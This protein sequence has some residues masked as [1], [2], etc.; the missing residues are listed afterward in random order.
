MLLRGEYI[1]FKQ[2]LGGAWPQ[3]C[4]TDGSSPAVQRALPPTHRRLH[5]VDVPISY[6]QLQAIPGA[7]LVVRFNV[8]SKCVFGEVDMRMPASSL[9]NSL[10]KLSSSDERHNKGLGILAHLQPPT[11]AAI[12][13]SFATFGRGK[14]VVSCVEDGYIGP[15][16]S[17]QEARRHKGTCLL[18]E[19]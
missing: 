2:Y 4:S 5:S 6:M 7:V 15:R 3:H 19:S 17:C 18:R 8:N 10:A 11:L 16:V 14:D 12:S 1:L 9:S 13:A